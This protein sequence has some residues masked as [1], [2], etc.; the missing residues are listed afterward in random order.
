MQNNNPY[1]TPKAVVAD[2]PADE[3]L[4]LASRWRRL[5]A[6]M[7]DGLVVMLVLAVVGGIIGGILAAMGKWDMNFL[8]QLKEPSFT[9]SLGSA[10]IY[11]AVFIGINASRL[12]ERGQT[13]GKSA[14]GIRIVTED[15]E[16]PALTTSIKRFGFM[17]A[18]GVIPVAGSLFSLANVLCIFRGSRQC[19]HDNIA[20]TRV[21]NA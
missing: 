18:I 2:I 9:F 11:I 10:V 5:F 15:G 21:V 19:L 16:I 20:S 14:L 3:A 4:V 12:R 13:I 7:V 1:A 6:S 8:S 17:S